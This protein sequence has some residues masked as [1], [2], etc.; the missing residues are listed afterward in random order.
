MIQQDMQWGNAC[1]LMM[2]WCNNTMMRWCNDDAMMPQS[3]DGLE[4]W[5]LNVM[6]WN[7]RIQ[8]C[9]NTSMQ[10]HLTRLAAVTMQCNT[11]LQ[12]QCNTIQHNGHNNGDTTTLETLQQTL[13]QTQNTMQFIDTQQNAAQWNAKTPKQSGYEQ[14]HNTTPHKTTK[15]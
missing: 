11:M 7:K 2:Q 13:H 4:M 14:W 8:Q 15:A 12:W 5:Q 1:A 6:Q 9:S 10:G 3:H